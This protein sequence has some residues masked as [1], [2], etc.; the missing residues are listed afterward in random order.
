LDKNLRYEAMLDI[1]SGKKKLIIH[2]S[3]AKAIISAIGICQ[4]LWR[5]SNYFR[6]RRRMEDLAN[7]IKENKVSIIVGR[8]SQFTTAEKMMIQI[9]ISKQLNCCMTLEFYTQ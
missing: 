3:L 2:A 8:V 1:W 5:Y 7:F 9:K 4:K 6:S